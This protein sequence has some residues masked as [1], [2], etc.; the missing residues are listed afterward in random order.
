MPFSLPPQGCRRQ[1]QSLSF[2]LFPGHLHHCPVRTAETGIVLMVKPART[3]LPTSIALSVALSGNL[4]V[5]AMIFPQFPQKATKQDTVALSSSVS[6]III[7]TLPGPLDLANAPIFAF[8]RR[9]AARTEL[10]AQ[11]CNRNRSSSNP[12][13]SSGSGVD[14]VSRSLR[15]SRWL[16]RFGSS[17]SLISNISD[18]LSIH[19]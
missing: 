1:T 13:R 7:A 19:V 8:L 9:W 16:G 6:G 5:Q 18:T 12:R 11:G 10:L 15:T 14:A 3:H 2:I 17:S 4:T